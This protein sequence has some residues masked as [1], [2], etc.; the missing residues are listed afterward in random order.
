MPINRRPIRL[1]IAA[2][3]VAVVLSGLPVA[4]PDAPGGGRAEAAVSGFVTRSGHELRLDGKRFRFTGFN[5]Q[6]LA[7]DW[8]D[9]YPWYGPR[10]DISRF[11]IR[12]TFE[13]MKEAGASVVR[14]WGFPECSWLPSNCPS[15]KED[16]VVKTAADYGMRVTIHFTPTGSFTNASDTQEYKSR[17]TNLLN[18]TNVYT[19]VQYKN[20]PTVFAW[21]TCNECDSP[22]AWTNEVAAHI[23]SV[24]PNHLVI[25]GNHY[26]LNGSD[27]IPDSPHVDIYGA[28]D[29][30]TATFTTQAAK[31]RAAGK[32]FMVGE[33]SASNLTASSLT[34]MEADEN[35][36]GE[37]YWEMQPHTDAYDIKHWQAQPELNLSYPGHTPAIRQ[38]MQWIREHAYRLAGQGTP[39]TDS[40]PAQPKI[41]QVLGASV[42]W[43]GAA[44]ALD[45][46]VE[47]S[48][49]S[50]T[51]GFT[52]VC[53]RCANDTQLPWYDT[54]QPS[55]PVWYRVKAH[56]RAGAA[57][58]YS[59]VFGY[60]GHTTADN[61]SGTYSAGWAS[62]STMS[63]YL[64]STV[65]YTTTD[66]AE[67]SYAFTGTGVQ[68]IGATNNDHGFADVYIDNQFQKRIDT[69]SATHEKQRPLFTKLG[70]TSGA[71]TIKIVAKRQ[72]R[73]A[74]SDYYTDIDAFRTLDSPTVSD[75]DNDVA[76]IY[77]A[78]WSSSGNVPGYANTSAH[79]SATT[80]AWVE[81]GFSGTSVAWYGGTNSEH[82]YADVY[83]DGAFESTVDT[84][85]ATNVTGVKLFEKAGLRPSPFGHTIRIVVK[86]TRRAASS[87]NDVDV[88]RFVV[89]NPHGTYDDNWAASYSGSDAIRSTSTQWNWPQ[90]V[91]G[92][93]LSTAALSST[94]GADTTFSCWCTNLEW[95]ASTG[96]DRGR[97]DVYVDGN[98]RSTVDQYSAAP[99]RQVSVFE[100]QNLA[101]NQRHTIRIVVA[102]TKNA[103]STGTTVEVDAF[104]H[105]VGPFPTAG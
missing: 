53:N 89:T 82:G 7:N 43:R 16:W 87:G 17:V 14:L 10:A 68:V 13:Q 29:Y 31:A 94:E 33:M 98:L 5:A 4:F 46:T 59:P 105:Y 95:I 80:D 38:Q 70:L 73:A 11:A 23:K 2:P 65:N 69:Y 61:T 78:G 6:G 8:Y 18:R 88:D 100:A 41:T 99:T 39:T 90:G 37:L 20:D 74:S 48:T 55:G 34:T 85:S 52:V 42:A 24:D 83:I 101:P 40:L 21:S 103:S 25:D 15:E 56:N 51:T 32:A 35:I 19:G 36:S 44:L 49:T 79:W 75:D 86:G 57:G 96:P 22:V 62:S 97:A 76:A 60:T 47:R 12:D 72:K 9:Y 93:Y 50:A 91:T 66:N 67:V 26:R 63:G 54:T 102:G 77:S 30:T 81:Y 1:L 92:A 64:N 71:H 84:Y 45:Y 3:V 58:P 27:P 104:R 28:H